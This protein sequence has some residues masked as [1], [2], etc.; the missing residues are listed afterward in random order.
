M[1]FFE[2]IKSSCGFKKKLKYLVVASECNTTY[3]KIYMYLYLMDL[4]VLG[5]CS[6]SQKD[7]AT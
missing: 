7:V 6:S 4:Q 5:C 2:M 3:N 1:L